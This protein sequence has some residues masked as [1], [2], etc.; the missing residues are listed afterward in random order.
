MEVGQWLWSVGQLQDSLDRLMPRDD[1]FVTFALREVPKGRSDKDAE[2]ED[3]FDNWPLGQ[4]LFHRHGPAVGLKTA[5]GLR[6]LAVEGWSDGIAFWCDDPRCGDIAV[7]KVDMAE[8]Q[9]VESELLCFYYAKRPAGLDRA[10]GLAVEQGQC[11]VSNVLLSL[12]DTMPEAYREVWGLTPRM[13][14]LADVL[15]WLAAETMHPLLK[16]FATR[17]WPSGEPQGFMADALFFHLKPGLRAATD[18]AIA[19]LRDL[20]GMAQELG[21]SDDAPDA[22]AEDVKSRLF[23]ARNCVAVQVRRALEDKAVRERLTEMAARTWQR[24]TD[25]AGKAQG[26]W[27]RLAKELAALTESDAKALK[28][29][30]DHAPK[31]VL[32]RLFAAEDTGHDVAI[33]LRDWAQGPL[34][35]KADLIFPYH[36][37][38]GLLPVDR[39]VCKWAK[40]PH[41]RKYAVEVPPVGDFLAAMV[42]NRLGMMVSLTEHLGF[43]SD[44]GAVTADRANWQHELGQELLAVRGEIWDAPDAGDRAAAM[45]LLQTYLALEKHQ[46]GFE[47]DW[48]VIPWPAKPENTTMF[49]IDRPEQKE[50]LPEPYLWRRGALNNTFEKALDN[51]PGEVAQIVKGGL[52][53]LESRPL[54]VTQ[55]EIH[56]SSGQGVEQPPTDLITTAIAVDEYHAS[57]STLRRAKDDGRLR[58]YRREGAPKNSPLM[59][60]RA[61]IER[62]FQRRK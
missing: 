37:A 48:A 29:K 8:V 22:G 23:T 32:A 62:H 60:S 2:S 51:R 9:P 39:A 4:L 40:L 26:L 33:T 61:E 20:G 18:Y 47:A 19:T 30:A 21:S 14:D 49:I 25:P 42:M 6:G 7:K 15:L 58:D 44:D 5:D 11:E 59:L 36:G 38:W 13:T 10:T 1:I 55:C 45:A 24:V 27:R 52:A 31:G 34:A 16:G 50:L 46:P 53:W 43:M 54:G 12:I 3:P 28:L 17:G 57:R 56:G 41:D 35:I